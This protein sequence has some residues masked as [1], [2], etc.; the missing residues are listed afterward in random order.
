[1]PA[2]LRVREYDR[3]R[4]GEHW[5]P[6][7]SPPEVP[8]RVADRIERFQVAQRRAVFEISRHELRP[9]QFVGTLCIGPFA[10]DVL[11]K[12][13]ERSKP[14]IRARLLRMLVV[15]RLV[16]DI[17]AGT[18]MLQSE[19]NTLLDVFMALY[20]R[21]LRQEWRRGPVAHYQRFDQN[22]H[23]LKGKLLLPQ[24]LRMNLMHPERFFTSTD[25]FTA[26]VALSRQLK[27]AVRAVER[28][29]WSHRLQQDAGEL[30]SEMEQVGDL[31]NTSTDLARVIHVERQHARFE[32]LAALA[33]LIL[34]G[35]ASHAVGAERQ[36]S[37]LFDMNVV[38]ERY[39]GE[40]LRR[41][42][43]PAMGLTVRLQENGGSLLRS[44][45]GGRCF[46][47]QPDIAIR[48][49]S[50]LAGI[51]DTKWKRLRSGFPYKGVSQSDAYQAWAYGREFR[52][53]FVTL[54]YPQNADADQV[55]DTYHHN[56]PFDY[57]LLVA[58]VDIAQDQVTVEAEL[59]EL[60]TECMRKQPDAPL[61]TA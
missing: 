53:P 37:L 57:H 45:A 6:D 21:R 60:L 29:A 48:R 32:P 15:G 51:I 40:L 61:F 58:T 22:R 26:N 3:I 36:Y 4:I 7:A 10:I 49:G 23:V 8:I 25:T 17:E 44:P 13:D 47:L 20:V 56:A 9:Q 42:V 33:R 19:A 43:G 52:S 54:L 12:I 18:A 2:I 38:F 50:Q 27:A 28:H 59:G 5:R 35:R 14:E 30:A 11:P 46:R 39:V 24:Q 55:R 16:P 31:E 1:M 34:A 41:R